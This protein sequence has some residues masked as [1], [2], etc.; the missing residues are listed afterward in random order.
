MYPSQ[1]GAEVYSS[2][3]FTAARMAKRS[4]GVS[5][6]ATSITGGENGL[7]ELRAIEQPKS[8]RYKLN[9]VNQ[10]REHNNRGPHSREVGESTRIKKDK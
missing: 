8:T 10:Y 6:H 9:N 3:A 4:K 2:T 7:D 5:R 1:A